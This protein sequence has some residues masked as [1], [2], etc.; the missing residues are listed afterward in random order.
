MTSSENNPSKRKH[1]I[2]FTHAYQGIKYSLLSQPNFR[3]HF[4]IGTAAVIGGWVIGLS[5]N[6]WLVL[7]LTIFAVLTAEMINTGIES[8]V[9]LI[10]PKKHPIAKIAKDVSAGSVLITAVGSIVVGMIIF[11]PHFF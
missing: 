6:E 3:I 2:S 8:T 10:S 7:I 11:L 4:L 5:S 1:G 9:D